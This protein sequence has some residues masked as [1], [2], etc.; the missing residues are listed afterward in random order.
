[1]TRLVV[2]LV[3]AGLIAAGAAWLADN[4][5][6]ATLAIA[7]Y[8]WRMNAS[9]AVVLA[10]IL[11]AIIALVMRLAVFL[12]ASPAKYGT[13]A[14]QRQA[15]KFFQSLSRG[16]I[17][18][19]AGDA[20]EAGHFARRAGKLLRGQPLALLLQA[21]AGELSGDEEKQ[22]TSYRDM[23]KYPETEF[24]GLRG[25][26]E[27]AMRHHDEGEAL[28]HAT[29]AH[30]LKPKAWAMNALFDL[31]VSRR[32]WREAQALVVQ[33]TRNRALSPDVARRR[34]AVLLAAQAVE[35][36]RAGE[37]AALESAL[38]A[39]ALAPGLTTAALIA[40]RHLTAQ[41]RSRKARDVI[42]AA[43]AEA[44]YR[45]LAHAFSAIWPSDPGEARAERLIGL[46]KL[47]P[48]HRESRVLLAEQTVALRRW[49]EAR[50]L[51]APLAE[52]YS[53]ARICNLMA[54]L[55]QGEQDGLTAQLWRSRAAR[56][57]RIADWRCTR[58]NGAA[59]E[60]GA[61]C[62]H[63]GAFDTLRWTAPETV[64]QDPSAR[65]VPAQAAQPM[66]PGSEL[67]GPIVDSATRG[68]T[69]AGAIRREEMPPRFVRPDDPGPEGSGDLFG[70][71]GGEDRPP[72]PAETGPK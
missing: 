42:E 62:P 4:D 46:A 17:A 13:W 65:A 18:A 34:R 36:D 55:A 72:E 30:A 45:D 25:L 52:D 19:A 12:V 33:A 28:A 53:S 31:R 2:I 5:G 35:A 16:L 60:W 37:A 66:R 14:A 71:G 44:P 67:G 9:I 59:P 40:A 54:E 63:C 26:Y 69:R 57:G 39:L 49:N 41:G 43:W 51:L 47:N 68:R 22:E 15:R 20:D 38:E 56:G 27:L 70:T 50:N 8:E 32:E 21:Q 10:V 48:M 64:A 24:L 29:R 61:V 11:A 1:M 7:G 3:I 23:L 6:V 58:C